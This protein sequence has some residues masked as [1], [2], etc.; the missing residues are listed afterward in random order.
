MK[1]RQIQNREIV[2]RDRPRSR[3]MLRLLVLAGRASSGTRHRV[4]RVGVAVRRRSLSTVR[5]GHPLLAYP[6][7]LGIFPEA[8]S[9]EPKGKTARAR[10]PPTRAKRSQS[11]RPQPSPKWHEVGRVAR[12]ARPVISSFFRC[13][14][15][16]TL[17][18]GCKEGL[19][20][21]RLRNAGTDPSSP[22]PLH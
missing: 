22:R 7:D 5:I 3:D 10:R 21:P 19:R 18:A 14:P 8:P 15:R 17:K 12:R 2:S 16:L 6:P 9:R 4:A 20:P 1:N 11:A 13:G